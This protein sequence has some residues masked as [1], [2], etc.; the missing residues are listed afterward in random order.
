V[1]NLSVDLTTKLLRATFLN[2]MEAFKNILPELYEF[3]KEYEPGN[4]L[5][6]IDTNNNVNLV[7]NGNLVYDGDPKALAVQQVDA[8]AQDPK[9]FSYGMAFTDSSH[10]EHQKILRSLVDRRKGDTEQLSDLQIELP[11]NE[12]QLDF[13]IMIGSGLGY[14]IEELFNR[15]EI[16]VFYLYES[17]TDVFFAAMH[18]IDFKPL[19]D[20][21]KAIGGSFTISAGG[22]EFQFVNQINSLLKTNGYFLVSRIFVYRHYLSEENFNAFK[23]IHEMMHRYSAGWGFFEDETI[24]LIHTIENT[25]NEYPIL[26][27]N[28]TYDNHLKH[29]SVVIV[30]NGPSL[31]NDIQLLKERQEEI[32]IISCGTAL[33]SLLNNGITPHIHVEMERTAALDDHYNLLSD[34][35]DNILKTI[36]VIALNTV[37]SGLLDRFSQAYTMLKINDVGTDLISFLEPNRQ[38]EVV[39]FCNPTVSNTALMAVLHLG[40]EN[41]C[42]L[43]VDLGFVD[44]EHHHSKSSMYYDKEWE[45]REAQNKHFKV[46]KT[47]AAE[48]NFREEIY[49]TDIFD[50]SKGTMEFALNDYPEL[51]V[52]N[53][54]D[55]AKIEGTTPLAFNEM[56]IEKH[57]F[58]LRK[59]LDNLLAASF[60]ISSRD[61][62]Y[63]HNFLKSEFFPKFRIALDDFI[64]FLD[65]PITSREEL[66]AVFSLQCQ[67]LNLLSSKRNTMLYFRYLKGT[68]NYMQSCIMSN[69]ANYTNES[70]R[71]I[72]IHD[73]LIE[74]KQH[75]EFLYAELLDGYDKPSKV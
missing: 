3:F 71:M 42:L 11:F 40:F 2:N 63:V 64:A 45:G 27:A 58:D 66:S 8:F 1:N 19:I 67:Y 70:K 65:R 43:G 37:Y 9:C 12:P 57:N 55:G 49:T 75:L 21:C 74:F 60:K 4:T 20:R 51:K 10:F 61:K 69:C 5:L 23:L 73:A 53:C 33:K 26:I 25:Q 50:L 16:K 39:R 47:R 46:A 44:N 18:C 28:N 31:D 22:N 54:S 72:F 62:V 36:P 41:I 24:S 15:K 7:D 17:S 32:I 14:Q 52:Y 29:L 56:T 13:F 34:E 6:T 38:F 30:G 35:E 59:E 68:M 48:G